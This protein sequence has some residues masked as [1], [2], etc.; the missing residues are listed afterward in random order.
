MQTEEAS[1]SELQA[2]AAFA[3]ASLAIRR[4]AWISPEPASL[5]VDAAVSVASASMARAALLIVTFV[6]DVEVA[7]DAVLVLVLAAFGAGG[8]EETAAGAAVVLILLI[9]I[10]T[11]PMK[12]F[13]G[14]AYVLTAKTLHC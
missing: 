1:G 8:A 3:A 13:Q 4:C 10:R 5:A 12:R 14:A 7:P 9:V 6:D 11:S 2:F